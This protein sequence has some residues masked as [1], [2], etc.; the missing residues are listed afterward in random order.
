[1]AS[2]ENTERTAR[3]ATKT[4]GAPPR[5]LVTGAGGA[6]GKA[7]MGE[8]R[9]LAVPAIGL[10]RHPLASGTDDTVWRAGDLLTPETLAPALEGIDVVVHCATK[11]QHQGEDLQA[12]NHLLK[13]GRGLSH[14]V[15]VGIA[16]IEDAARTFA[17]YQTKLDCEARL[18]AS[19]VPYTIARATQFHAFVDSIL[20]STRRGPIQFLPVMRV[21]PVETAYVASRLA[22]HAL[23]GPQGRAP[24]IHGPEI[25]TARELF[26][27]WQEARGSKML[28]VQ[29]AGVGRMGLFGR[30]RAVTG[31]VG[32]RTWRAWLAAG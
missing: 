24:D 31:D 15:Y 19:G 16:G 28:A 2:T 11:S 7:V 29:L 21:Q 13:A 5:V 4:T 3:S 23:A 10:T 25:L 26:Q 32:G 18:A 20:R 1:M 30:L 6:L 22:A 8:F 27:Q 17:Y 14:L 12:L 9:R